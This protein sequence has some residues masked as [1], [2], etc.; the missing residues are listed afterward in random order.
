MQ[1]SI[2]YRPLLFSE[3]VGQNVSKKILANTILYNRIPKAILISGLHGIG[4]TT[5]AKIYAK[6]LN[7]GEFSKIGEPCCVCASCIDA[8]N[9]THFDIIELDAASNNGVDD[10]RELNNILCQKVSSSYRVLILDEAHMLSKSAQAALLKILE[11]S[12]ERNIFFLVTTEPEKLENT[13]RS[14]C[15][16]LTLGSPSI[17]SIANNIRWVLQGEEKAYEESFVDTLSLYGGGSLRDVQQIL[18][19]SILLSGDE[20]LSSS[21]L[22]NMIGVL[23][24]ERYKD[25]ASVLINKDVK[26]AVEEVERWYN[27]G[28]DLFLLYKIGIPTLVR[29]FSVF[30]ADAYSDRIYYYSGLSH[31]GFQRNLNLTLE[32]IRKIQYAWEESFDLMKNSEHPKIMMQAFFIKV[33]C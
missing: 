10:I 12:S 31:E 14:R 11:E 23:S 17:I 20:I 24:T 33:C 29:D 5:L 7:C 16:P 2:K 15:I 32:D 9:G 18:E 27:D 30:L 4:K 13:I 8:Q 3:V 21:I 25:L 19:Q 1:L 28:V 22:E 6:S 26:Y